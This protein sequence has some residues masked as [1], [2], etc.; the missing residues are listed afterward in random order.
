VLA[1][2]IP[3]SPITLLFG[4][5]VTF[6]IIST[7]ALAGTAAA[8]YFVL[9]RDVVHSRGAAYLGALFCGFAPAM[10]S[11]STGH[12]NIAGQFVV[13][14][15]VHAVLQLPK[16][17]SPVRRG[18]V[19]GLLAV[20]QCSQRRCCFSPPRPPHVLSLVLRPRVSPDAPAALPGAGIAVAVAVVLLFTPWQRFT[21]PQS[22]VACRPAC[23]VTGSDLAS[24][25]GSVS[26]VFGDVARIDQV[27]GRAG[28]AAAFAAGVCSCWPSRRAW[29]CGGNARLAHCSSPR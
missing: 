1:L 18:L 13:P 14:F 10:V 5:A 3:L 8:W 28:R 20:I 17:G 9:S 29:R 19:L 24:F 25:R 6:A 23:S 16:P 11:Q 26:S 2:A 12:P 4:A 15:V 22:Y 21:R 7:L 27:G